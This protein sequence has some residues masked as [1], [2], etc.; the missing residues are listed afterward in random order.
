MD[1][2]NLE[3]FYLQRGRFGKKNDAIKPCLPR[4]FMS[5]FNNPLSLPISTIE[6]R[7]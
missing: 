7:T 5:L 2:G 1:E 3:L 6:L 4:R